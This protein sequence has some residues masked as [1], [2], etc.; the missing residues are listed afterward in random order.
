MS[1]ALERRYQRLLHWY[2]PEFRDRYGA[3]MLGVLMDGAAPGQSRPRVGEVVDVVQ[4]AI[5]RRM[6][7]ARA[8]AGA[9]AWGPAAAAVGTV[10][11]VLVLARQARPIV[12]ETVW[13]WR[14]A[15]QAPITVIGTMG[16]ARFAGWALV[17][18][19]LALGWR[20]AAAFG[21][22]GVV[23]AELVVL[24]TD[25]GGSA[26]PGWQLLLAVVVAILLC[27]S[28]LADGG[29]NRL[30]VRTWV[31]ASVMGMWTALT[32]AGEPL[33]AKRVGDIVVTST[34]AQAAIDLGAMAL[35][36]LLAVVAMLT[37]PVAQR[38]RAIV[39]LTTVAALL[40]TVQLGYDN[41]FSSAMPR[42]ALI[43]HPAVA[44]VTAAL[45]AAVVLAVGALVV[46]LK[47]R[48]GERGDP[49]PV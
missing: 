49:G 12:E 4:A 47:E 13:S 16:W 45:V 19:A 25:V 18:A 10:A 33:I 46:H 43:G 20:V 1:G 35:L 38:G 44:L 41:A 36:P 2:P 9:G 22:C 24:I 29:R 37:L 7:A 17:V 3:E 48:L 32:A 40:A 28:L 30:P 39:L 14:F 26:A 27:G 15:E 8:A 11:V 5:M 42:A 23:V 31:T 21:A 6:G 34:R